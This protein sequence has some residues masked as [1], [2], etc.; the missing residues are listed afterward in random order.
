MPFNVS[1]VF[2]RLYN[3]VADRDNGIKI[4]AARMD[5][6]ADD[7][8]AALNAIVS[9]SQPFINPIMAPNGTAGLP[10]YS[11]DSDTNLGM[12]R[13]SA[14]VLGFAALGI[15]ALRVAETNVTLSVPLYADPGTAAAPSVTFGGTTNTGLYLNSGAIGFTVGGTR[16]MNLSSTAMQLDVPVTGTEFRVN[17]GLVGTA[18]TQTSVDVTSGRILKTGDYG[19]GQIIE[20]SGGINTLGDMPTGFYRVLATATGTF[21]SGLTAFNMLV[22]RRGTTPFANS[23]QVAYGTNANS[24][25]YMRVW[26]GSAWSGWLKSYDQGNILGTVSQSGGTPTGAVI[27]RGSNG[28][29]EFV[30]FADGTQI[31]TNEINGSGTTTAA[32]SL[33]TSGDD[34]WTFPQAF[35]SAT[36]L[37]VTAAVTATGR[38]INVSAVTASTATTRQYNTSSSAGTPT[39]RLMAIGRWF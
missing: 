9:Q 23:V 18:V 13:V 28:N 7:V 15:T 27:Q 38:W 24:D 5:G 21:P 10:A 6:E 35:T 39:I 36:G 4:M 12:Y 34:T 30:R 8:A 22:I 2:S 29:G 16:R 17:T 26:D 37:T 25:Q 32:G 1:G 11:F 14:D 19:L 3:W 20:Y 33:Y 31:C